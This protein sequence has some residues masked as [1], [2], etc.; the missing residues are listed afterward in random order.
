MNTQMKLLEGAFMAEVENRLPFQPR[1]S[2]TL[3][4]CVADGLLQHMNVVRGIV[5]ICG[6][7]LT[8]AGRFLYCSS[9]SPSE[10]ARQEEK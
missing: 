4:R 7:Q 8:H 9:C 2:K 1:H 6:Y 5:T 10:T 3:R